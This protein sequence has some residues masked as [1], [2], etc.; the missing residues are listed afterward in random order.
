[1]LGYAIGPIIGGALAQQASWRVC[2]EYLTR[3]LLKF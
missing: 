1:M 3:F 2:H